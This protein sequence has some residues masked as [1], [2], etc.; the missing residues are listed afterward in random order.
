MKRRTYLASLGVGVTSLVGITTAY[1]S[2]KESQPAYLDNERVVY[3]HEDLELRILQETVRLGDTVEFEVTNTS[4]SKTV[5]G[6][7]N[8]WAIQT[9]SD[10][11]WRHVTW[12][13]DRYY[14]QCATVL[15][16]GGSLVES[17]K[18]TESELEGYPDEDGADL[19]PGHYRFLVLGSS[20]YMAIDFELLGA[21]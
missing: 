17:I 12:T 4:D 3:E 16:P 15:S 20:P 11:E 7:H 19:L 8:P 14:Q 6:C 18:L 2:Q 9:V 13:G 10:G 21:E 1:G 5:L